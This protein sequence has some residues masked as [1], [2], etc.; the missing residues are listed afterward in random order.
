MNKLIKPRRAP[1]RDILSH[2]LWVLPVLLIVAALS[3]RQIDLYPPTADEFSSMYEA[4]WLV[5]SPY[6]PLDS[7]RSVYEYSPNHTP[8][9]FILL[10]IWGNLI[11]YDLAVGRALGVFC[12][13]LAI[14]VSYRLAQD[15]IAPAAG[16]FVI[17]ILSSNAFVSFYFAH[18]RMYAA[19][20]LAAGVVLWLYLRLVYQVK[21]IRKGDCLA[22]GCAVFLLLNIHVSSA[23]FLLHL[24]L[25][26]LFFVRPG[27]RWLALA[28]AGAVPSLLCAP[29]F[30]IIATRGVDIYGGHWSAQAEQHWRYTKSAWLSLLTNGQPLLLALAAAGLAQAAIAK[31]SVPKPII[32][33]A[34]IHFLLVAIFIEIIPY[35]TASDLRILLPSFLLFSLLMSAGIVKLY[36]RRSLFGI[37][38]ALWVAAGLSFHSSVDW[39][40]FIRGRSQMNLN[41][42]W[43]V[44]SRMAADTQPPPLVLADW[45]HSW[46]LRYQGRHP[47]TQKMHYFDRRNIRIASFEDS[48]REK[49]FLRSSATSLP[50]VWVLYRGKDPSPERLGD[51]NLTMQSLEYDLCRA[52]PVGESWTIADYSWK[53]LKCQNIEQKY[54]SRTSLIDY[55]FYNALPSA[56]GSRLYLVGAWSAAADFARDSFSMS[57]QLISSDWANVAQLDLPLTQEGNL[58]PVSIDISH[59]APGD[60]RLMLIMYDRHSGDRIDW[61]DNPG[62]VPTMLELTEITLR[63]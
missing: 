56:D 15:F 19:L 52:I 28:L 58:R 18:V 14:A 8:G 27:R 31:Q 24:A 60:Y 61:I 44:I 54:Y 37:L 6:S 63:D 16:F 33:L 42:P 13:L 7:I 22:L 38:L 9:Y 21:V 40:P 1:E 55:R 23:V 62:A 17:I 46:D 35:I 53:V 43:Q 2:W 39:K 25:Y 45:W 48:V 49:A 32:R 11:S 30:L 4:G 50:R 29:W 5:N 59:V 36:S 3:L 12:G 34:V 20:L 47:F 51:M 41:P 10:N 57:Y 26:H